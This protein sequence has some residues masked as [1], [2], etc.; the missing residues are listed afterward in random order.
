MVDERLRL[1]FHLAQPLLV[2]CLAVD[3]DCFPIHDEVVLH[4]HQDV[5]VGALRHLLTLCPWLEAPDERVDWH[6]TALQRIEELHISLGKM[7]DELQHGIAVPH[8]LHLK[9]DAALG[10]LQLLATLLLDHVVIN[11]EREERAEHRLAQ[12]LLLERCVQLVVVLKEESS[13]TL[14]QCG[15]LVA[16]LRLLVEGLDEQRVGLH[17]RLFRLVELLDPH[18]FAGDQRLLDSAVSEVA[19]AAVVDQVEELAVETDDSRLALRHVLTADAADVLPSVESVDHLQQR[20]LA[21]TPVTDQ[22]HVLDC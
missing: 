19:A 14:L 21:V 12:H 3:F 7:L 5:P 4:Q 18:G 6:V 16:G 1:R 17:L 2:L 20:A 13:Q 11:E 9:L 10:E 8:A 22:Q 15:A